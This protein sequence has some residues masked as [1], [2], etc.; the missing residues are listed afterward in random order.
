MKSKLFYG[1][2]LSFF[3]VILLFSC[4]KD[5]NNGSEN[6][7]VNIEPSHLIEVA[8]RVVRDA[9]LDFPQSRSANDRES[10][11]PTDFEWPPEDYITVDASDSEEILIKLWL[12]PD[13][14]IIPT[15]D[16]QAANPNYC[17]DQGK[18]MRPA[19]K[20]LQFKIYNLPRD[21]IRSVQLNYINVLDFKIEQS[22]MTDWY[23]A[24]P[25]WMYQAMSEVWG[26]MRTRATI[27]SAVEPCDDR[28]PLMLYFNS[29]VTYDI[30]EALVYEE[31]EFSIPL[32][33][34]ET[35]GKYTGIGALVWLDGYVW[36][37]VENTYLPYPSNKS[38]QMEIVNLITPALAG[39]SIEDATMNFRVPII[40]PENPSFLLISFGEFYTWVANQNT[41]MEFRVDNWQLLDDPDVIMGAYTNNMTQI[42]GGTLT[43]TTTIE[44]GH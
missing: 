16:W 24:H 44:I 7:E 31:F 10:Q 22:V 32:H 18:Y 35:E 37:K 34:D 40:S 27:K 11:R 29:T 14:H 39:N 20:L 13:N 25:D 4:N 21:G 1:I 9:G 36:N 42:D 30:A 33:F 6:D 8:S 38:G 26:E 41:T 43:E 3:S 19:R 28:I 2:M 5:E 23:E 12:G 15:P 17:L